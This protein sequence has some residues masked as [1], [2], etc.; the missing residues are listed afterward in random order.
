MQA[1]N[2]QDC[3]Y[4]QI[5]G[6]RDGDET[7]SYNIH[8]SD[9][10][11]MIEEEHIFQEPIF[12][13]YKYA[14]HLNIYYTHIHSLV[15]THITRVFWQTSIWDMRVCVS[16]Q[17]TCLLVCVRVRKTGRRFFFSVGNVWGFGKETMREFNLRRTT[18]M[19]GCYYIYSAYIHKSYHL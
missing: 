1:T 10:K 16:L 4:K 11:R 5:A 13:C 6:A 7:A 2:S 8:V 17:S 18:I 19:N 9:S 3:T 12:S 15:G 14:F